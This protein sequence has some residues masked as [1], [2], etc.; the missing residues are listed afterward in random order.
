MPL[1]NNH[2]REITAH[3][4]SFIDI[5]GENFPLARPSPKLLLIVNTASHCGFTGQYAGLEEI[6]QN[7]QSSGLLVIDVPSDNFAGQ[8]FS[9]N[10]QIKAFCESKYQITFPLMAKTQVKGPQ[11]HPFYL[12]AKAQK[13]GIISSPKWNFHKYLVD[14]NGQLIASLA[15]TTKP[16]SRKL[17]KLIEANLPKSANNL[18]P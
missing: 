6:W 5:Y 12:W 3:D 2:G 17:G 18:S 4:F 14:Q 13:M 8:E 1:K 7:Y 15:S 10:D 16:N 9:D 11:A